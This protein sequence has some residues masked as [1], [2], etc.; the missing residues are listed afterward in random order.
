MNILDSYYHDS[1]CK[2]VN[3]PQYIGF[4]TLCDSVNTLQAP[5]VLFC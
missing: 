1:K 3:F 4:N 2:H 5:M